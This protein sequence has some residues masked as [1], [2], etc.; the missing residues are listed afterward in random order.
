MATGPLWA[1]AASWKSRDLRRVNDGEEIGD[2]CVERKVLC[3][4]IG[5]A[6]AS[7][8]IAEYGAIDVELVVKVACNGEVRGG[9]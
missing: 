5:E 2:E 3:G 1:T 7:R 4:A 6:E 9:P 8:V